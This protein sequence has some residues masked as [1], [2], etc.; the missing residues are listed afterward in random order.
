[1]APA[2]IVHKKLNEPARLAV[3]QHGVVFQDS[4]VRAGDKAQ[5]FILLWRQCSKRH[6]WQELVPLLAIVSVCEVNQL[7]TSSSPTINHLQ[8]MGTTPRR[9]NIEHISH[10]CRLHLSSDSGPTRDVNFIIPLVGESYFLSTCESLIRL[11][12]RPPVYL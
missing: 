9:S 1:M 8:G 5:V 2:I 10:Q 12:C 4:F 11:I 7:V 3:M 6:S